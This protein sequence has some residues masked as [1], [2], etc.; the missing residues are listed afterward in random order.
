[1]QAHLLSL[2]FVVYSHL[3]ESRHTLVPIQEEQSYISRQ[4]HLS[5]KDVFGAAS[6]FHEN[7]CFIKLS[8]TKYMTFCIFKKWCPTLDMVRGYYSINHKNKEQLFIVNKHL[9]YNH[10]TLIKI[11]SITTN[12]NTNVNNQKTIKNYSSK[13]TTVESFFTWYNRLAKTLQKLKYNKV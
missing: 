5:L 11:V 1:M 3:N 9:L 4:Q 6:A 13:S 12:K 2:P 7:M 10:L 8:N